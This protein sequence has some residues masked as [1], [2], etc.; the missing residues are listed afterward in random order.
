G[1]APAVAPPVRTDEEIVPRNRWVQIGKRLLLLPS[2]YHQHTSSSSGTQYNMTR[3]LEAT[4]VNWMN[5][6]KMVDVTGSFGQAPAV[7]PPVR[8]DEEIVPRNRKSSGLAC[9]DAHQ[10]R[11]EAQVN[12]TQGT[13]KTFSL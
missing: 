3:K 2:P 12:S 5:S 7:A 9:T 11:Q 1:Q 13:S 4:G 10:A 8:T 6:D